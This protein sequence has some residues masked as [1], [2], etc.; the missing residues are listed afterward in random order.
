MANKPIAKAA[1]TKKAP[2]PAA[3]ATATPK[4]VVTTAPA[5]VWQSGS[6]SSV[7]PAAT[8]TPTPSATPTPSGTS[9]KT[10]A[11]KVPATTPQN[12]TNVTN[13]LAPPKTT[14]LTDYNL[15]SQQDIAALVNSVM[16]QFVGRNATAA[17]IATYGGE[18]LAAE[19][20]NPTIEN[21]TLNRDPLTGLATSLTG[22]TTSTGVNA[23]SFLENLISQTGQAKDFKVATSY[24]SSMLDSNAKFKGAYNG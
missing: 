8:V 24:M 16:Q 9:A 1:A 17:E 22:G 7:A 6:W 13:L 19:R 12:P 4:P 5:S 2:A 23:Q 11:P 14:T 10:P 15:T 3:K 21:E 20:A 18:L